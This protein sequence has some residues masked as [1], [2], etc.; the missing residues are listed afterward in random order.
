MLAFLFIPS[1]FRIKR[2]LTHTLLLWRWLP[3]AKGCRRCAKF[4]L[5]SCLFISICLEALNPAQVDYTD[6]IYECWPVDNDFPES[7]S[8]EYNWA[9][10]WELMLPSSD[11]C[12]VI[13]SLGDRW[14]DFKFVKPRKDIATQNYWMKHVNYNSN[15]NINNKRLSV[16]ELV[17]G[18]S[19]GYVVSESFTQLIRSKMVINSWTNYVNGFYKWVI[20]WFT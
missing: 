16:C 19:T 13:L 14:K 6:F 20:K 7:L 12:S 15:A 17:V 11:N 2:L 9:F 18:I 4:V 1:P 3:Q 5:A 8:D 10:K